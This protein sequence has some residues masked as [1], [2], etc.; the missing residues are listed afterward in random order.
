MSLIPQILLFLDGRLGMASIRLPVLF[1]LLRIR[2]DF[3]FPL[4]PVFCLTLARN[5]RVRSMGRALLRK[6]I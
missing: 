3:L 2:G 4:F 5:R 1:D 6:S